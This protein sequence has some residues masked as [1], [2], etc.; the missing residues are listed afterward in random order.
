MN[1]TE[2][3]RP[4]LG[5][6]IWAQIGNSML[7]L[8]DCFDIVPKLGFE[9]DAVI[10]DPPFGITDCPWDKAPPL[11]KFWT[12]LDGRA[13]PSANFVLF[14][15]GKFTVDLVNSKRRWYRYD[16]IWAKNNKVGFLNANLQPM[17]SHETILVFGRPGYQRGSVYNPQKAL[18]GKKAGVTTRNHSSSVYRD[19]G[20]HTHV[21]DG[22]Q[23]PCSL[24]YFDSE[25]DKRLHP[26]LKPIALMEHLVKSY[27]DE[28]DIVCDMFM[29][30][31]STGVAAINAGRRFVGIEREQQYFDIAVR[32]IV[33]A[34]EKRKAM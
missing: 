17:R 27:S 19:R 26:T 25:K 15:C 3:Q 4:K 2:T 30:S 34:H 21:S 32:R 1:N 7:F 14:G 12:M 13:K 10:S 29:G 11:D 28:G 5:K 24:L 23:H 31:G 33:E 8:G 20:E 16:L 18:G 9:L 6:I 22:T